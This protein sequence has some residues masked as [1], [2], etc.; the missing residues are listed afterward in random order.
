VIVPAWLGPCAVTVPACSGR[1][2]CPTTPREAGRCSPPDEVQ[3]KG[4]NNQHLINCL[5][6]A[7]GAAERDDAATALQYMQVAAQAIQGGG[8]FVMEMQR[9]PEGESP[10]GDL[11]QS[12][13]HGDRS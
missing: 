1:T 11:G 12:V 7:A 8:M 9:I 2:K 3:A 5:T 6:A 4:T 10:E 13:T